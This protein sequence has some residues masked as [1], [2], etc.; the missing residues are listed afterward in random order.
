MCFGMLHLFENPVHKSEHDIIHEQ[1]EL[2]RAA[3]DLDFDSVWPAEHHFTEYGYCASPALSLAAIASETKRIR[4]GTGI[5]ILPMNHP[6]RVAED[7]AFLDH[8]SNGRI[9]LGVGRGYQPLEFDRYGIE[10]S[11]TRGQFHEALDVIRQAWTQ[12]TVNFEGEHYRFH[13]V[14]VRPKP[15]QQPHPPIWMA[16][17]SPDTF[18]MAGRY[19]LDIMYGS[20]FGLSPENA[21]LRR[22][23]YYR[24]LRA[25]GHSTEGRQAGCLTMIYVADTMEQARAEFRDPVLWYYKT[26]S[27][28]VAPPKGQAAVKS[29]E[30]YAAFR[31]L[32]ADI[33][34]DDLLEREAVIC[35]DPDYVGERLQEYQQ[36]YGFT[37]L[38]CWTRLGGL[39]HKKVL[40]SMELMQDKVIPRL[41]DA[42]PP[43]PPSE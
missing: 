25:A 10:Q 39:D 34:W 28:Y 31:D 13:D 40:R 7:Y 21:V 41:R 29:Y 26:I 12:E 27:K 23:D 18:E 5:V 2:M 11:T 6:L 43:P 38:L 36:V 9:D 32:L 15:F 16:A 37:E 30:M 19:G 22:A 4:L 14:P 8:L 17:L 24:G 42:E 35:G 3:E 20:V 1:M 33:D